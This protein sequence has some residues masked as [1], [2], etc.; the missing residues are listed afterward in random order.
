MSSSADITW[1][2]FVWKLLRFFIIGNTYEVL[3]FATEVPA[4]TLNRS[5]PQKKL[6]PRWKKYNE[7]SSNADLFSNH[8]WH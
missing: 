8:F 2:E 7:R 5:R 3:I 1:K 4:N 6:D